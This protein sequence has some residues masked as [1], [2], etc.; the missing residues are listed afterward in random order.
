VACAIAVTGA[1]V[2]KCDYCG[3]ETFAAFAADWS[4]PKLP[5]AFTQPKRICFGCLPYW[6]GQ[7]GGDNANVKPPAAAQSA[8]PLF[9]IADKAAE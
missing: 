1:R 5:P 9:D 7:H 2:S 3:A 4:D 6:P 8:G